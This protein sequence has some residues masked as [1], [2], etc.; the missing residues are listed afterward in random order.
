[1]KSKD[2]VLHLF[3]AYYNMVETK[4]DMKTRVFSVTMAKNIMSRSLNLIC[5]TVELNHEHCV[6]IPELN[7][8]VIQ[9]ENIC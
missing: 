8:I 5:L 1:M 6:Y 3:K 4:F 7:G 2:E 9:R